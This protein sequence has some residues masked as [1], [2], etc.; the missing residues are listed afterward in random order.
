MNAHFDSNHERPLDKVLNNFDASQAP[1]LPTE[2]QSADLESN[3]LF[4]DDASGVDLVDDDK[5]EP[6]ILDSDLGDTDMFDTD[7]SFPEPSKA[8]APH[9]D[10]TQE[11]EDAYSLS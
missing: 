2:S 5:S 8:V 11:E 6:Y 3:N 1:Q 10:T 9:R 4:D 7:M